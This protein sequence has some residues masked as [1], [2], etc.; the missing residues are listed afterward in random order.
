MLIKYS[1]KKYTVLTTKS[2]VLVIPTI[3]KC[4]GLVKSFLAPKDFSGK[5]P[6]K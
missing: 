3:T 5:R 1:L 4:D 2:L 6:L